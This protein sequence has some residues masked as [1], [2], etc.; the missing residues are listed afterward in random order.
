MLNFI[1][2]DANEDPLPRTE[3]QIQ[4]LGS[5]ELPLQDTDCRC[6]DFPLV[7]VDFANY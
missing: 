1:N 7:T 4:P 3:L 6:F 2:S 5:Q